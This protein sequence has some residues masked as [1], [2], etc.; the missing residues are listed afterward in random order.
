[1]TLV[2]M[3][4]SLSDSRH[5]ANRQALWSGLLAKQIEATTR[6]KVTLVN[7]AIGGTTLSQNLVLMPRWLKD[8]PRPDL[9]TVWFGYNDFSSGVR[10]ERFADYL[11]LAVD[12]V[13]RMTSGHADVLLMTT[14]PAYARWDTMAEMA[15]AVRRVAREKHTGLADVAAACHAAGNADAAKAQGFWAPDNTHLGAKGHQATRET[16]LKALRQAER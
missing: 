7:P 5:W 15:E 9:V 8:T 14:C 6:S 12:R 10:G 13:R 1:I 2:T 3:G 4:D 16:V 11:A